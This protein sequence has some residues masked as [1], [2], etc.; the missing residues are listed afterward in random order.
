METNIQYQLVRASTSNISRLE[1]KVNE[2]MSQGWKTIGPFQLV[3]I[4]KDQILVQQM[5]KSN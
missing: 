5:E 1:Q 2:L 4:D 3:Q